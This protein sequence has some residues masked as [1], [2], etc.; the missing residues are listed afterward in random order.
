M[1]RIASEEAK[2]I[3]DSDILKWVLLGR[4]QEAK[5]W[6]ASPGFQRIE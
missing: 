6:S 5:H 3:V 4:A 1:A 2:R